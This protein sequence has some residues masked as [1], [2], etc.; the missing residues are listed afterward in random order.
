MISRLRLALDVAPIAEPQIVNA[1]PVVPAT[2]AATQV[3]PLIAADSTLVP[4]PVPV[5]P[6]ASILLDDRAVPQAPPAA[7]PDFPYL[8]TT[9]MPPLPTLTGDDF[10]TVQW[11]GTHIGPLETWIPKTITFHFEPMSQAPL[12]GV[13]SIGMGTVTGR[14]GQTQTVWTVVG[15]A[16]TYAVVSKQTLA[17]VVAVGAVW[18]AM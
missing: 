15:A 8:P 14:T 18:L 1:I 2:S 12:P 17:A 9:I 5:V 11:V 13:G 3:D 7:I 10:V 6:V 4:A 16:P